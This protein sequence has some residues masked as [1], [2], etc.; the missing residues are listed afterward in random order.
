MN[1][2]HVQRNEIK[3]DLHDGSDENFLHKISMSKKQ[4]KSTKTL[5][6]IYHKI[7]SSR[8]YN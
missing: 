2:L 1:A 8:I 4:Q 6:S 7:N 5:L 3:P